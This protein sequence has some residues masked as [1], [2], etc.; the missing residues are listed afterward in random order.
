MTPEEIIKKL[1]HDNPQ[2]SARVV[3]PNL[4]EQPELTQ[5]ILETEQEAK[6]EIKKSGK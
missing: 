4:G 2:W 1:L 5:A 3:P 6:H